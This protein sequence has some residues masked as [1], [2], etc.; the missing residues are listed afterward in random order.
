MAFGNFW[1]GGGRERYGGEQERDRDR[2]R[3]RA[4]S[5]WRDEERDRWRDDERYGAW[6]RDRDESGRESR[7]GERES[8]DY[9]G[10]R[11]RSYGSQGYGSQD[12]GSRPYGGQ[13]FGG[14]RYRGQGG[15][16]GDYGRR[17]GS[18]Q[19]DD[20]LGTRSGSSEYDYR[21]GGGDYGQG[22]YGQG[23]YGQGTFRGRGP[24]GY[25]RSDE[26]IREDV[27]DCLT[28]DPLLDASNMEVTVKDCEV[29]LSGTVNRR[30]D[31]RRAEDLVEQISGV[32]DVRNNLRVASEQG[33]TLGQ[34]GQQQGQT[35]QSP[36][37]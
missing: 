20:Y 25:R 1:R 30:E 9:Y 18:E 11:S 23:G 33:G 37:H 27:C 8:G 17:W 10:D 7:Y 29:T 36:R 3:W 21:G 14:E 2:D 6:Q 24:R 15:S 31:K 16:G 12:Y 13:S 28:D 32:K 5:D 19:R 26:R 22:S 35:G 34:Q 4:G